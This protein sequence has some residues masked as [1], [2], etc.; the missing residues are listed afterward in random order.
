MTPRILAAFAL[1]ASV[2]AAHGICQERT[3]SSAP[4]VAP[5]RFVGLQYPRL[6]HMATIQ[7][8]V[9]LEAVASIEGTVTE[10][11]TISGHPLLIDAARDSLRQ[12]HFKG[13]TLAGPCRAKATFVFVLEAGVCELSQC[14]N[15]IQVDLPS[16]I[17]ITSK[18]ARAIIN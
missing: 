6:A 3:G 10:V 1:C 4:E 12:W 7:G 8:R 17:T 16:T 14:P 15:E 5:V 13:C 18:P 9:E 2:F 11:R